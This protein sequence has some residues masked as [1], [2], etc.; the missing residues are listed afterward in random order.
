[1]SRKFAMIAISLSYSKKYRQATSLEKLVYNQLHH[2]SLNNY[3]GVFEFDASQ[4]AYEIDIS[5]TELF[6]CLNQLDEIDLIEVDQDNEIIRIVDWFKKI[7]RTHNLD[8][9]KKNVESF[10][11]LSF[12][13]HTIVQA[14]IAE[15]VVETLIVGLKWAKQSE[16]LREL[17]RTFISEMLKRHGTDFAILLE[18]YI[19]E[20]Y[21]FFREEIESIAPSL[22]SMVSTQSNHNKK[23]IKKKQNTKKT[24]ETKIGPTIV[25]ESPN[26]TQKG[27]T[28]S[29]PKPSTLKNVKAR[30]WA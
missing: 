16:G 25:Q 18:S 13:H 9:A 8:Q 26:C 17:F 10:S 1:M 7:N 12:A 3:L 24:N 4:L 15:F 5:R 22:F 27:K 14:S 29:G 6:N 2:S 23:T 20:N 30:G 21:Q 28:M 19:A 11:E